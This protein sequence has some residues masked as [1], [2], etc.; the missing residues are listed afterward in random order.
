MLSAIRIEEL[1]A[2]NLEKTK[3]IWNEVVLDGIAFPQTEPLE[4]DAWDFFSSQSFT[5]VALK[6]KEVIGMYIL[7]P[8]NVGRCSH[9]ANASYA[10]SKGA[11]NCHIGEML[12]RHSLKKAEELGFRLMQF[13][14]VVKSN[15]N[16]HHLYRKIGFKELGTIPGGFRHDSG[17]YEDII[18]YIYEF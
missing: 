5:A 11:R 16:A 1:T 4:E 2:E 6:D 13:N 10:V 14:A 3:E 9:I 12:V 15:A 18:S 17:D 7:H 8:N